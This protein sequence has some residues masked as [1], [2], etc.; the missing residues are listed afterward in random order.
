MAAGV[1]VGADGRCP[2]ASQPAA[3]QQIDQQQPH[4]TDWERHQHTGHVIR[5][6]RVQTNA[7]TIKKAAHACAG[8]S[9]SVDILVTSLWLGTLLFFDLKLGFYL[10]SWFQ[11][12]C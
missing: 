11:T 5:R 1:G 7:D 6:C 3:E 12:S 8:S 4:N 2:H 9:S 10:I